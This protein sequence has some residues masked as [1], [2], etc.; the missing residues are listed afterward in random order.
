MGAGLLAGCGKVES[1]GQA[2][3]DPSRQAEEKAPIFA[4]A[5][6]QPVVATLIAEHE[7]I[8]PGGTTRVG[9]HF[10][11]EK[12]WH[13]YAEEPGDAGLPTEV[14]WSAP[15]G[16]FGPIQWPTPT[17]FLDP[18]EIR[19]FGYEGTVVL[20]STYSLIPGRWL[21]SPP[22]PIP[23]TAKLTWLACK[24]ICIPGSANLELPLPWSHDPPALSAH[25]QL[26]EQ[27]S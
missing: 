7:S 18:G 24:E 19:T 22:D 6:D 12:G 1:S 2:V 17:A 5:D 8:Q 23:I 26:F 14:K 10:E 15:W 3:A 13:I 20:A 27:T 16:S 4:S 21:E 9:V 25:A 11:L